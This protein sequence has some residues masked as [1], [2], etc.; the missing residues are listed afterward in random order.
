M[1]ASR[2]ATLLQARCKHAFRNPL[3]GLKI[4]QEAPK[5]LPRAIKSTFFRLQEALRALQEPFKRLSAGVMQLSSN[6]K[7]F[8]IDFE[9]QEEISGHK[10]SKN[11]V[12]R[13]Q[14]FEVVLS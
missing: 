4:D 5:R 2:A 7:P 9:L 3:Y 13:P 14:S 12:K 8:L 10:K 6:P 11:F 1:G